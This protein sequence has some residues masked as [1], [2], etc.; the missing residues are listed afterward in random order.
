MAQKI[1]F[2]Y[3]KLIRDRVPEILRKRGISLNERIMGQTEYIERLKNKL[4]EEALEV[5]NSPNTE[6]L[7]EELADV[8]EVL[9]ALIQALEFDFEDIM[10]TAKLKR[11]EKGGFADRVYCDFIEMD[12]NH[13]SVVYHRDRPDQYPE[14]L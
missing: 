7:K 8:L 9:T 11:D 5:Q 1:R 14:I 3:D 10:H 12:A 2:K 4:Q 6:E 13:Q